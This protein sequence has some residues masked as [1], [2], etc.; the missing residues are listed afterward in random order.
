MDIALLAPS[1]VPLTIGGAENLWWG[2]LDH[3]NRRTPHTAD[4]IKLPTP[5]RSFWEIVDSYQRWSA[6][7]A[8]GYD[9]VISGKYPSWIVVAVPSAFEPSADL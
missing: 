8:S 2:L 7:D 5:E 6:L 4:L 9:L 1:P 3:L